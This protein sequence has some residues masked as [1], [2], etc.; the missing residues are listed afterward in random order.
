MN[1]NSLALRA[2]GREQSGA[3]H[4]SSSHFLYEKTCVLKNPIRNSAKSKMWFSEILLP[5]SYL[6]S[7]YGES[8]LLLAMCFML[9]VRV[10]PCVLTFITPNY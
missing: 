9:R 8:L 6:F 2:L 5:D 10:L 7:I 4:S 1:G 3:Y